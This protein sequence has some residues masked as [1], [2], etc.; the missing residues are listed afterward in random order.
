[1]QRMAAQ[2]GAVE[3]AG[4]G[5]EGAAQ[6]IG[7]AGA[8][9]RQMWRF[10]FGKHRAAE[11]HG[12][13]VHQF[14]QAAGHRRDDGGNDH[15]EEFAGGQVIQETADGGNAAADVFLCEIGADEEG[16]EE[17]V[18]TEEVLSVPPQAVKTERL[19]KERKNF[20]FFM[21]LILLSFS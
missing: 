9:R 11:E 21:V 17:E 14:V 13:A 6:V 8:H 16:E 2:H 7:D 4:H 18:V 19:I 3:E 15:I 20:A 1:M 12:H 5:V 10:L